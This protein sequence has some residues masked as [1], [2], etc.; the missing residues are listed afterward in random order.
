MHVAH[1]GMSGRTVENRGMG[2][3]YTAEQRQQLIEEVRATGARVGD[4]AKR[5]GI[6]SSSAYLWMK[7]AAPAV[8]APAFAR[9]VPARRSSLRVEV[10]GVAL[11][12]EHGF[13]AALL[14]EVVAALR[15]VT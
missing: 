13:D 2:N 5:M 6:T 11:T 10:A 3:R 15:G 12:V 8:S 4:V 14:C 1:L 7:A 9:V